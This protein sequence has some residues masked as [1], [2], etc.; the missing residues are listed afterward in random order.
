MVEF[1]RPTPST[2]E[3]FYNG[4]IALLPT[5]AISAFSLPK[6]EYAVQRNYRGITD[7][8]DFKALLLK[9]IY[10]EHGRHP[11]SLQD[12]VAIVARWHEGGGVD[13]NVPKNL[14]ELV[15]ELNE[16]EE[17][18]K[19]A[20]ASKKLL[21]EAQKATEEAEKTSQAAPSPETPSEV[22]PQEIK[23]SANIPFEE[24]APAQSGTGPT[25][26]PSAIGIKIN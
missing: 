9:S 17:G 23:T 24:E 19:K 2:I 12:A 3:Y 26:E 5:Y 20:L 15:D 22:K 14:P 7:P 13:S 4:I 16:Q 11:S 6:N 8:E 21:L 1:Q 18:Y 25:P 10:D